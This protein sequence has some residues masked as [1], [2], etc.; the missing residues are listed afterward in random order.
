MI[1]LQLLT[2]V[3]GYDST[4]RRRVLDMIAN[5]F[6][7]VNRETLSFLEQ[8]RYAAVYLHLKQYLHDLQPYTRLSE[9]NELKDQLIKLHDAGTPE[10]QDMRCKFLLNQIRNGLAQANINLDKEPTTKQD[11]NAVQEGDE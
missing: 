6:E 3:S 2:K 4:F 9:M 1:N 11:K 8:K 5:R 7:R 10:E